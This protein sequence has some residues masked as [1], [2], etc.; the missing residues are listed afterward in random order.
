MEAAK[1]EIKSILA[2]ACLSRLGLVGLVYVGM[3]IGVEGACA[4]KQSMAV[5]SQKSTTSKGLDS[6]C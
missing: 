2:A 3:A 1:K 4:G 6:H 5:D